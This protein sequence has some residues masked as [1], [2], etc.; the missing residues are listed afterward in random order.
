MNLAPG[1]IPSEILSPEIED[2]QRFGGAT[3]ST[4]HFCQLLKRI[5]GKREPRKKAELK[6]EKKLK[7]EARKRKEGRSFHVTQGTRTRLSRNTT[8]GTDT[9]RTGTK[10]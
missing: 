3:L 1:T 6:K 5:I 9:T 4:L 10:R 7:K 2:S 8:A